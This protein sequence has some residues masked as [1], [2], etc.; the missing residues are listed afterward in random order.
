M[1]GFDA[2]GAAS[3]MAPIGLG[4]YA[5]AF[6][7]TGLVY[8]L[9]RGP[10]QNNGATPWYATLPIGTPGQNLKFG[11]DTGSNFIWVTSTLCAESGNPCTHYGGQEFAYGKSSSFV[12][13]D[14]TD[15]NV[16]FGPWG[17]WSSRPAVI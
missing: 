5:A 3:L 13:V 9:T 7:A 14:R 1:K 17:R 8:P 4:A 15:K 2:L 12:W 11:L 6:P 16:S 10:Y